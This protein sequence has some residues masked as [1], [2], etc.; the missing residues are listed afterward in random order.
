MPESRNTRSALQPYPYPFGFLQGP[1]Y[2]T[3][4][5]SSY[6]SLSAVLTRGRVSLEEIPREFLRIVK[7]NPN[8]IPY[9]YVY[10]IRSSPSTIHAMSS[11]RICDSS[12]L[13]RNDE[14]AKTYESVHRG[15][16]RSSSRTTEN[17]VAA[18]WLGKL[19]YCFSTS[20]SFSRSTLRA[21]TSASR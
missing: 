6:H 2:K 15:I 13:K 10:R 16:K 1:F 3:T 20:T 8:N 14:I 9:L 4:F 17:S 19:Q 12:R 7:W 11:W 21:L 18:N 5:Q